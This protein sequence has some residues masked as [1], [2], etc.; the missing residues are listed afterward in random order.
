MSDKMFP[1]SPNFDPRTQNVKQT[2]I[3]SN[4]K[5]KYRKG[6]ISQDYLEKQE[7]IRDRNDIASICRIHPNAS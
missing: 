6:F 7:E 1:H 5:S 4:T 3:K 2:Y